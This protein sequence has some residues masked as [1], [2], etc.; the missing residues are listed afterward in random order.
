[1][2]DRLDAEG[3]SEDEDLDALLDEVDPV[4]SEEGISQD[5]LQRLEK[6]R[7]KQRY[8]FLNSTHKPRMFHRCCLARRVLFKRQT[9]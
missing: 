4:E 8:F 5:K 7:M 1:M 3:S 6:I 2:D 9:G